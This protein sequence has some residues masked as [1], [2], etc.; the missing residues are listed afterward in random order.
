MNVGPVFIVFS[1]LMNIGFDLI[2]IC[3]EANSSCK[4]Y[5]NSNVAKPPSKRKD[6]NLCGIINQG[7]TCYLNTLIQTLYLTT[8]FRG[9][10]QF[11]MLKN[12]I[13]RYTCR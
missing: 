2:F 8:E 6:V 11:S 13:I 4:I 9:K 5:S 10:L 3:C 12:I 7:A 1:V